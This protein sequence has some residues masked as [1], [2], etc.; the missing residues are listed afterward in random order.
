MA[1]SKDDI[2]ISHQG[3][4]KQVNCLFDELHKILEQQKEVMLKKLESFKTTH[5]SL[6]VAT[7]F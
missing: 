1:A 7:K 3:N 5:K 6:D 2:T 4:V